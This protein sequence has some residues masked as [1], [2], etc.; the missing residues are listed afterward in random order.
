M[1]NLCKALGSIPRTRKKEKRAG[2]SGG[3]KKEGWRNFSPADRGRRKGKM[4]GVKFTIGEGGGE[5]EEGRRGGGKEA[6]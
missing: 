5:G 3:E 4:N 2:R 6:T 1:L